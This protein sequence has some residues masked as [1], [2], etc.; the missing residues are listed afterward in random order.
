MSLLPAMEVAGRCLRTE[1][2]AASMMPRADNAEAFKDIQHPTEMSG[3]TS[4]CIEFDR[5]IEITRQDR[6]FF[7]DEG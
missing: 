3:R 2:L 7:G 6:A 1:F 5:L 4:L